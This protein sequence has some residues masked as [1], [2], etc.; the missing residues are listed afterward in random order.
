MTGDDPMKYENARDILPESLL[1]ELQQYA[2]G[3]LIYI[4]SAEKKAWGETSGY[5]RYLADRNREIRARFHAG[6]GIEALAEEFFLSC[7]TIKRIVYSKKEGFFSMHYE[8]TVKSAAAFAEAGQLEDWVHRYLLTDGGNKEF[9][10]GLKLLPRRYVGPVT[11]PLSLFERCCGPEKT[12][13]WRVHPEWF[14]RHVTDIAD[15]IRDG[16]ELPPLIV[17]FFIDEEHPQ[18][19]FELNDGNHRFEA[20]SR[21]GIQ[22]YPVIFWITEDSEYETFREKYSAYLK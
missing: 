2:A 13:R 18:G 21:L 22:E 17:H 15:F 11:M 4:P 10:E 7:D 20:F 19:T 9:S 3:K 12:M 1:L 8:D 6:T 16:G 14:E 5:K